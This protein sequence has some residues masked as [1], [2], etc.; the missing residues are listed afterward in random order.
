MAQ[1]ANSEQSMPQGSGKGDRERERMRQR[2]THVTD[3]AVM[4]AV[5][6]IVQCVMS[7]AMCIPAR[8]M[9]SLAHVKLIPEFAQFSTL[10]TYARA[11]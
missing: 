3:V 1:H 7:L 11:S 4:S 5:Y 2:E 10:G 9:H 6:V 8:V